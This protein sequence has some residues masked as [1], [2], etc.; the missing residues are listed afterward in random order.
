MRGI[1]KLA[2]HAFLLVAFLL[3][4]SGGWAEEKEA[5]QPAV[6]EPTPIVR[7]FENF[8]FPVRVPRGLYELEPVGEPYVYDRALPVLGR[9]AAERGIILPEPWGVSGLYVYNKQDTLI[10]DLSVALSLAGPPPPDTPLQSTPFVSF[11]NVISRTEAPQV[12]L[13][14]WVLPFL[15]AFVTRGRV[16]GGSDIDVTVDL[17]A[18]LPPA[19]CPPRNPCGSVT[20][21]FNA[22]IDSDTYTFGLV[23]VFNWDKN[24]ITINGN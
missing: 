21:P 23:G 6:R 24:L 15:N 1:W 9:E 4:P 7:G 16:R 5:P 8:P 11:N 12:K 22:S 19:L 13:D 18:F 20:W 17:D 14:A 10:S 3:A 2:S